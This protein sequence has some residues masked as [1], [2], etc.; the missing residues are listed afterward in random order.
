M[1]HGEGSPPGEQ[2]G[3]PHRS[4]VL[5]R[6][7]GFTRGILPIV[8]RSQ[9]E[10]PT[11]EDQLKQRGVIP[12]ITTESRPLTEGQVAQHKR[13]KATES[14]RALDDATAEFYPSD[15]WGGLEQVVYDSLVERGDLEKAK[16]YRRE[17]LD[18]HKRLMNKRN[19]RKDK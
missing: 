9:G 8:G 5:G 6:I 7:R 17:R 4:S 2:P 19:K 16:T 3:K 12:D 13:D 18:E 14:F 11:L 15:G 1:E 10:R